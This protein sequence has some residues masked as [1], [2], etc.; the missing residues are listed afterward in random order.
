MISMSIPCTI[1]WICLL[2]PKPL[3]MESPALFYVG[4]LFTGKFNL[5]AQN[6]LN[7]FRQQIM[8]RSQRLKTKISSNF[9]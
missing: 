7:V 5:T 9:K 2:L 3:E 6:S 4:R 8:G 1:G